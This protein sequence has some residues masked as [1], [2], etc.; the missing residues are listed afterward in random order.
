MSPEAAGLAHGTIRADHLWKRFRSDDRRWSVSTQF[1]YWKA[2]R[3]SGDED[4]WRWALRDIDV[5]IEPGEAVG[6]VGPNG[7]G[8]STLLKILTRVMHPYAGR[9]AVSGRVGALIEVKAGIHNELS[10]RENIYLY[11]SLLGL[12][13]H[14]VASRFDQIIAFSEL[15]DAIDRQVKF[16]SSGMQMRLGFSV[17]AHLDPDILL[18][19]EVL[20][21][22]DAS[23]QQRCHDRMREVLNQG[24]TLVLVS[25]DL[26]AVEATCNRCMLLVDGVLRG[27]GQ[28][29]DVLGEYREWIEEVAAGRQ[30]IEAIVPLLKAVADDGERGSP[31]SDGPLEVRLVL[32]SAEAQKAMLFIGV[33]EGPA[34]PIFVIRRNMTLAAGEL[35]LVC[36]VRHL[37]LP[38][39]RFHVWVG[40]YDASWRELLPWHP[41]TFFDVIG[42]R[43]MKAPRGIV[44]LSPVQVTADWDESRR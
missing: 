23:F 22:G 6:L 11:G 16:Y 35:E 21:V 29:R 14:E 4:F 18:V 5:H 33:S 9:L 7:S 37:P 31:R 1:N 30:T 44:R 12:N 39:G 32:D 13:R 17:A 43:L 42:N 26:A 15:D 2:R 36:R 20:A 34:T 3:R 25:H 40:I 28:I 10:G 19:D 8:K 41:A 24:T 38:R 27:D